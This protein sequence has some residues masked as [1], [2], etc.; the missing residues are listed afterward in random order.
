[1]SGNRHFACR[2]SFER[3]GCCYGKLLSYSW[4]AFCGHVR[5]FHSCAS[6]R[7]ATHHYCLPFSRPTR[8]K[9]GKLVAVW[10]CFG[11]TLQ[12]INCVNDACYG[13][14]STF[15]LKSFL[16][17][18]WL[19]TPNSSEYPRLCCCVAIRFIFELRS[20]DVLSGT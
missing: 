6:E 13:R 2:C 9:C 8:Q 4:M 17:D 16:N 7:L 10:Q 1:M 18:P 15:C 5:S 14:G 11:W 3:V 19:L 12:C 20:W